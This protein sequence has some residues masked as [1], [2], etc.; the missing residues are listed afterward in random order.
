MKL[1]FLDI[2]GVLNT[3]AYRHEHGPS[4]LDPY[5]VRQLMSVCEYTDCR[6]VISSDR[7]FG[8]HGSVFKALECC[9]A[10]GDSIGSGALSGLTSRF[11]GITKD[12]G[13]RAI[14]ISECAN[15][16]RGEIESWCAVDVLDL[17][18]PDKNFVHV[19]PKRGLLWEVSLKV[20][21]RLHG[22]EH[23]S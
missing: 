6:I 16:L 22:L 8:G 21:E 9:H 1:L 19:N 2:D 7:R 10:G 12:L 13:N 15:S 23:I 4:A 11:I 14:E 20:I 3:A 5:L 18:L 17:E